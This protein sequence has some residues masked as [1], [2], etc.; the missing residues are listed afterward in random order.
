MH[1]TTLPHPPPA[2]ALFEPSRPL[3]AETAWPCNVYS[4]VPYLGVIF[5]PLAFAIGGFGFFD[6]QRKNRP[7]ESRG[8]IRSIAL[9][10]ILLAVQIFLW[11]LLY[12]IPE[13]Q[14]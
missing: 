2:L 1:R 8:A 5:L 7:K 6:A 14:L 9:S 4:M 12:I 13:I 11:W 3:A 10:L